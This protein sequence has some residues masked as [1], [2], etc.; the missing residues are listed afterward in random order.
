[1]KKPKSKSTAGGD[2]TW[3]NQPASEKWNTESSWSP[4]VVPTNKAILGDSSRK[5]IEFLPNSNAT[6]DTIEFDADAPVYTFQF[7]SPAPDNPALAITGKG[8][9]NYSTNI[10]RFVVASTANSLPGLG[11]IAAGIPGRA[12]KV[13]L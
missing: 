3:G 7:N 13:A 8:V 10:Q 2:S 4:P 1:M 6:V 11:P 5:E 9:F 12:Q